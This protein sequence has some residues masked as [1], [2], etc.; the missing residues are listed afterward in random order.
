MAADRDR[1][2]RPG[3]DADL[4][5]AFAEIV[6]GWDA[7]SEPEG[8]VPRWPAQE[9]LPPTLVHADDEPGP[10]ADRGIAPGAGEPLPGEVVEPTQQPETSEEPVVL[11]P[12]DWQA[13][14]ATDEHFVPPEPPPLPR[15]DLQTRLAW[16]AVLLGPAFLVVA[17]LF[18]TGVPRLYLGLAALAFVGGFVALVMRLPASRDEDD[19][20]GA[21]V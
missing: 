5:A 7:P 12:R 3:E 1:G 21:V 14:P 8:G 2:E 20:D 19:D 6:R 13:A 17:G 18:W 15:G 10:A 11:G 16:A 4:D 9:D